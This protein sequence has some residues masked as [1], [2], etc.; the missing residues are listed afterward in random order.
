[1]TRKSC[2]SCAV[3]KRKCDQMK[4]ACGRCNRLLK[5]CTYTHQ[6]NN[7]SVASIMSTHT[8]HPYQYGLI[9]H[10]TTDAVMTIDNAINMIRKKQ[11]IPK[12]NNINIITMTSIILSSQLNRK[13]ISEFITGSKSKKHLK[14]AL[15]KNIFCIH[16]YT[17]RQNLEML[18]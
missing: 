18:W 5:T 14:T 2:S 4:P 3:G 12:P 6:I 16:H 11:N 15:D 9:K 8:D 7:E 1:M 17:K 10:K 13:T